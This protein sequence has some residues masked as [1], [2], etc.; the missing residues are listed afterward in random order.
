MATEMDRLL[1]RVL[2]DD[3]HA[4]RELLVLL[5][6]HCMQVLWDRFAQLGDAE[7]DILDEAESLL[8]EWSQ[9]PKARDR[10][11]RGD[12]LGKLAFRLVWQVSRD[13]LRQAQR[14]ERLIEEVLAEG[15]VASCDPPAP[16]L[17]TAALLAVIA[18]LPETCRDVLEAEVAFQHGN[19]PPLAEA[20]SVSPGAARVRLTRARAVLN[21]ALREKKLSELIE[22]ETT[23][24]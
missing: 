22:M 10:L 6:P 17:G 20:L 1:E 5:R 2:R 13:R 8:F 19:G 11:E 18:A 3:V 14:Q 4:L 16:G 24:G 7:A 12:T 23:D 15:G 9:G 21:R